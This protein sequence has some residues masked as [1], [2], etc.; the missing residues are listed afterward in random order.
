M[1][2]SEHAAKFSMICGV[3][4]QL[5]SEARSSPIGFRDDWKKLT[6]NK[7]ESLRIILQDS[8]KKCSAE[9]RKLRKDCEAKIYRGFEVDYGQSIRVGRFKINNPN[10][11]V[12]EPAYGISYTNNKDLAFGFANARNT[13]VLDASWR[14][15]I[16]SS[17]LLFSAFGEGN[18]F[19]NDEAKRRKV[20]GEFE[21]GIEDIIICQFGIS[22][23]DEIIAFP[24]DVRIIKYSLV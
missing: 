9:V 5:L 4:F 14:E 20:L 21:I 11:N 22:N 23:E 2:R 24:D 8:I 15:R 10:A 13:P 7:K 18:P 6:R 16:E 19:F 3:Y 17:R 12:F 1:D